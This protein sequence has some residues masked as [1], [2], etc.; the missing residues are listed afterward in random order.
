MINSKLSRFET[1]LYFE[2][3]GIQMAI[4]LFADLHIEVDT[5]DKLVILVLILDF[6]FSNYQ[7]SHSNRLL[8]FRKQSLCL[9]QAIVLFFMHL[10]NLGVLILL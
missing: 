6:L 1:W 4:N 10:L 2:V 9:C 3:L 5:S 7:S 8:D